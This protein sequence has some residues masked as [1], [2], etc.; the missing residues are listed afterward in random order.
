MELYIRNRQGE[1][2]YQ[3]PVFEGFI[4]IFLPL[5][6]VLATATQD[7]LSLTLMLYVR[8]FIILISFL[9]A[10][11]EDM[12]KLYFFMIMLNSDLTLY[13]VNI[14]FSVFYTI[15]HS[16]TIKITKTV[17][18]GIILLFW[19]FIHM[20]IYVV[21]PFSGTYF[22]KEL[23]FALVLMA[24]LMFMQNVDI[25]NEF[26]SLFNYWTTGL[27][28]ACTI[29]Y[30]KYIR[31]FGISKALSFIAGLGKNSDDDVLY[32]TFYKDP[33]M[34]SRLCGITV[35]ILIILLIYNKEYQLKVNKPTN[36][37]LIIGFIFFGM[38]SGAMSLY[39]IL[40]VG[41]ILMFVAMFKDLKLKNA[42]GKTVIIQFGVLAGITGV[43]IFMPNAV[44]RMT[45]D[46]FEG[47]ISSGRMDIWIDYMNV[48]IEHPFVPFFGVGLQDYQLKMS[49]LYG[50]T[51]MLL[52]NV[53]LE[54]IVSW[55]II[56][57][58]ILAFLLKFLI[59]ECRGEREEKTP[60][61]SFI[62]LITVFVVF[63]TGNFF[64]GYYMNFSFLMIAILAGVYFAQMKARSLKTNEN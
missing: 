36:I 50:I 49:E 41:G 23:G 42:L 61:V 27:L 22:V 44:N 45:R 63:L 19:E 43:M 15:K 35:I 37:T 56:G 31:R 39:L 46:L 53:V 47:D 33:N 40:A 26:R 8:Y 5:L 60:F 30:I 24:M 52:H 48:F 1:Q 28:A 16:F 9:L 4:T 55:G 64:Y 20:F 11:T 17:V 6:F 7:L 3:S 32:F 12:R 38:V 13:W 29:F 14:C 10:K 21:Y 34:V 62:P 2:T 58:V 59:S 54:V 51:S 57:M 18:L 25:V